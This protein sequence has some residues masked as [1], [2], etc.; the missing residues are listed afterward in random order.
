MIPR[1]FISFSLVCLSVLTTSCGLFKPEEPAKAKA[2][3]Y[4]WADDGGPGE[5]SV[6]IDLSEQIATYKRGDRVIGW[7]F[8][9]TGKE[10]HSTATGDYTITERLPLKLSNRYG[11]IADAK[12]T[13]T[14][15]DAKPTTPVPP[16]EFY[17]PSPMHYWMRITN[18]GIGLHAGEIPRPGEAA[19]HGCIRLPRDFVPKLYEVTKVGTPVKITRGKPRLSRPGTLG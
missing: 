17:H 12:G 10:G 2:V 1:L 11:W 7:S 8:V 9:S 19:S 18:Y 3:L 14:N 6:E 15:G 5:I 4:E 13:V 16:G